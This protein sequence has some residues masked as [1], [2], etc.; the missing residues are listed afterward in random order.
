MTQEQAQA[1]EEAK[2]LAAEALDASVHPPGC[3]SN[4]HQLRVALV[5]DRV[6]RE[7]TRLALE[8]A[9]VTAE[10]WRVGQVAPVVSVTAKAIAAAIR[11]LS[12]GESVASEEK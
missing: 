1:S 7:R 8:R 6:S 12:D 5:I 2:K 10:T 4:C 11:G 9:A 3:P